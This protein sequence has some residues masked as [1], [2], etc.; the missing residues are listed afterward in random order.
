MGATVQEFCRLLVESGLSGTDECRQWLAEFAPLAGAKANDSAALAAWLIERGRLSRYQARVLAAGR[1][2]PFD[3]REYRIH[4]RYDAGRLAGVFRAVHRA[5]GQPL[6]LYFL[7]N[8]ARASAQAIQQ[9]AASSHVAAQ[10]S[11]AQPNLSRTYCL[12]D[13]GAF[14][15]IVVEDL[16]GGTLEELLASRAKLMP[17]EACR[18][19]LAT[20]RGLAV[21]HQANVA[22]GDVRPA[23]IW[24]G[25][26]GTVKLLHFPLAR[27]PLGPSAAETVLAP[28]APA[29]A[30][31]EADYFAPELQT[32]GRAADARSDI[33]GLGCVLYQMLTQQVPFP[34]GTVQHKLSRHASEAPQALEQLNPSCPSALA[35]VVA[36]MMAKSPDQRFQ[37]ATRLMESLAPFAEASAT[38]IPVQP[39]A[40]GQAFE[41]WLRNAP[42]APAIPAVQ[43]AAVPITVGAVPIRPA[44]VQ[45]VAMGAMPSGE[46]Q[47]QAAGA[48]PLVTTG[49]APRITTGAAPII[50]GAAAPSAVLL[51]TR[52]TKDQRPWPLI[53]GSVVLAV[54][55]IGV[56]VMIFAPRGKTDASATTAGSDRSPVGGSKQPKETVPNGSKV[57]PEKEE[58]PKKIALLNEPDPSEV[59]TDPETVKGIDEPIWESPTHGTRLDLAYLAFGAQVVVTLRPAE[60]LQQPEAERL[61]DP[62]TLGPLSDLLKKDLPALAGTG[63]ENMRQVVIGLLDGSPGPPRLCFVVQTVQPVA[64]EDLLKAWGDPTATKSRD[65]PN[66]ETFYSKNGR[67]YYLPKTE[68]GQRIV[69]APEQEMPDILLAN[70]LA[71]E[72]RLQMEVLLEK[73]DD[74]RLFNLL[75]APDFLFT[76]GKTLFSGPAERLKAPLDDF[77]TI[78]TEDK[79]FELP[80]AVLLSLDL[81]D[82]R[83]FL[84]MRMDNSSKVKPSPVLARDALDK[85]RGLQKLVSHYVRDLYLSPYSKPVLWDYPEM[86]LSLVQQ[87]VCGLDDKQVVLRACLPDKSAHNLALGAYLSL[88]ETPGAGDAVVATNDEPKKALTV[89]ERLDQKIPLSFPRNTLEKSM[90]LVGEEIGATI[91]ILGSDLQLDGITKNQSFGIDEPEQP[92]R[93]ILQKIMKLANPAG[94]LIYV[95]KPKEG[96]D[97]EVI[98]I[99]TR[100][101]AAK[102]G[103]KLPPELVEP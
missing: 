13:L 27:D 29:K 84:E 63:L 71:P 30:P 59:E 24:L 38:Q 82:E 93:Q 16:Q 79:R 11:H 21:L 62:R 65:A 42:P 15:F 12:V 83:L 97:E 50:T 80:K 37:Q 98:Y 102:R 58:P 70:G 45:P 31:Q 56:V 17:N 54:V 8:A 25:Q 101:A 28:S 44:A 85:V 6:A 103:D 48:V 95:V 64:K 14:K 49:A 92:A 77:L 20:A 73:S 91:I 43:A 57:T 7:A 1:A 55:A 46:P 87:T 78:E 52:R 36:Y 66:K 69:M 86:V 75:I 51:R 19:A 94:K 40:T 67:S 74:Q 61:L 23:N 100:A 90:E 10:V 39:N 47:V 4:D 88:L 5:T 33:Y 35:R 9:L 99:T 3:Y 26:D 41:S 72:L 76:S 2:G 18:I 96:S 34:S 68:G 32:P 22:H 53:V 81:R 60:L 89:N